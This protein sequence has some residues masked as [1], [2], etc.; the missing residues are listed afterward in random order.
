MTIFSISSGWSAAWPEK[1]ISA[2][3]QPL[4]VN[5]I[6]SACS[7]FGKPL[8]RAK[9]FERLSKITLIDILGRVR[10]GTFGLGLFDV[11]LS[12]HLQAIQVDIAV[13]MPHA[14]ARV[15]LPPAPGVIRFKIH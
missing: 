11:D 7:F 10:H 9:I 8:S 3:K 4:A 6:C 15:K 1:E 14:A 12:H 2:I 5:M 13:G